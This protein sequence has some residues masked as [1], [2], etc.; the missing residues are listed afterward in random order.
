MALPTIKVEFLFGNGASFGYSLILGDLI[1]GQLGNNILGVAA[2]DIVDIT[3]QVS[4]ISIN[5][6]YNLIQAQFQAGSATVRI[7]D[8]NGDWNPQNTASPYFGKLVPLRKMRISADGVYIY[9]GY[10]VAYNYTYPKDMEIG[11]VDVELTDA[12]RLF[13]NANIT[14]VSGASA[15]NLTGARITQIL[16]QVGYPSSMRSIDAGTVTVLN[17]PATGRTALQ[18][19][20]SVE[21][22][23]IGGLYVDGEGK[24]TFK[25]RAYIQAQ[26]GTSP[27]VF[28]NDGTGI[29][30]YGITFSFDD[31]LII[32]QVS[33]TRTGGSAQTASD[34]DSIEKYFPHSLS[35]ADLLFE[36]DAQALTAAQLL[37]SKRA[38]T[39]IRIDSLTLDLAVG[40][41]PTKTAALN[42]N[43]FDTIQIKNVA[44][45]GTT[46]NKTLQ[47]M[48]VAHTITPSSWFTTFTTSEPI[49]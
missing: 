39:T 42:M 6:G 7:Y 37:V 2:A 48:G 49:A 31:K 23:E 10:T 12:F 3:N 9:S 16:D 41:A 44:Q 13:A 45:D 27:T 32:N 15:G 30:Y 19:M 8:P 20:K 25:D 47:C 33:L 24:V 22:V 18:A 21:F 5:R 14:S 40:D 34:T 17:D 29:P 46:I 4:N 36:T 11:F 43:F 26:T 1:Y 35:Y 38:Q 28:A